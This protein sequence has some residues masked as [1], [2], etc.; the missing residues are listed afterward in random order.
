ML[1]RSADLRIQSPDQKTLHISMHDRYDCAIAFGESGFIDLKDQIVREEEKATRLGQ[2]YDAADTYQRRFGIMDTTTFDD[3][4]RFSLPAHFR[5]LC[6]IT[7]CVFFIG[8]GPNI[9]IWSPERFLEAEGP[10]ER[11]KFVCRMALEEWRSNPKNKA[12]K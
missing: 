10:N 4:G 1:F 11:L 6:G 9:E 8:A 3:G 12:G 7:D 5:A 2:D